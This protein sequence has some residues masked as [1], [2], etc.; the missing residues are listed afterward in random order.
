MAAFNNTKNPFENLHS[1]VLRVEPS[2]EEEKVKLVAEIKERGNNAFK[3]RRMEEADMLYSRAIELDNTMHALYGNRSAVNHTMGKFEKAL[4]DA[5][6]AI[7]CKPDWAKGY[8]RKGEYPLFCQFWGDGRGALL[9]ASFGG[10]EV[11]HWLWGRHGFQ[12][13]VLFPPNKNM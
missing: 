5:I 11:S 4:E 13:M 10:L 7:N 8:F 1:D 6:S 12:M 9:F 2:S 3:T